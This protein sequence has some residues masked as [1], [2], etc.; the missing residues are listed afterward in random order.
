MP[1]S[2]APAEPL[3]TEALPAEPAEEAPEL[4]AAGALN[5]APE[6]PEDIAPE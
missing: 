4:A 3:P 1:A 2:A 5:P 6:L